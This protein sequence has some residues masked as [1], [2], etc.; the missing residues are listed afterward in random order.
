MKS[1][2]VTVLLLE[3]SDNVLATRRS[4]NKVGENKVSATPCLEHKLMEDLLFLLSFLF[5]P[6]WTDPGIPLFHLLFLL[7]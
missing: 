3:R 1:V 2:S 7:M 5:L 6:K 4:R